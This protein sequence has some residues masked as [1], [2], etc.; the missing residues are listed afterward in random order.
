MK[1]K[2]IALLVAVGLTLASC[3]LSIDFPTGFSSSQ[4]SSSASASSSSS[5]SSSSTKP[6]SSSSSSQ[7]SATSSPSGLERTEIRQHYT[8]YTENN[9][10]NLDSAPTE[11]P[12]RL[13]V[14]PVWFE[15]SDQYIEE[16]KKENVRED[17]EAAYF[18]DE[19]LVGWHS[20]KTFYETESDEAVEISGTVSEW[21]EVGEGMSYYG[22][23]SQGASRTASLAV[24]AKDWFFNTHTDEDPRDYDGD[25]D[26][27]LDG[28]MLIYAAPDYNTLQ[29]SSYSNLWAYCYWVQQTSQ[30]NVKKPGTNAF[31]WASYDF[32]YSQTTALSRAGTHYA[33][34]DTRHC[35]IDAH[36]Y[37]HEMGHVFG[38]EDYYDYGPKGYSPAASFSMQ[39]HNVGGHDPYSTMALGW[40]DPYIPTES[41]SITIG[42]FQETRELILLTPEWNEYDSPFDEYLLLELYTPT[43]LNERDTKY[44]YM[45][46]YPTGASATG[47]RLWHID[48]R[49]LYVESDQAFKASQMTCDTNYN[50]FYGVTHAFTNTAGNEDYGSPLGS[51]YDKYNLLQLVR[52]DTSVTMQTSRALRNADLFGNGSSFDINTYKKQFVK[53]TTLNN[54]EELGWSFSVSISGTGANAKA[55]IDLV[56]E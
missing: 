19:G 41:C 17:I 3:T 30:R 14:I 47:I 51:D 55:T 31:F 25:G 11:G 53:S 29:K 50:S 27:Y 26:G 18:G 54:G 7:S 45:S 40:S 48:A 2:H 44:A 8:D 42:A 20:V 37:I 38:L 5:S 1:T 10:Y 28:V 21:Y 24:S 32:L 9:V 52:N 43:G 46:Y 35:D 12:C 15:D 56:R 23:S 6:S 4:S 39:D 33:A 13:L 22:S 16:S 34:G 49:L 36:T